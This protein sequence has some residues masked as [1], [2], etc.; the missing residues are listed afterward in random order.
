MVHRHQKH[1]FVVFQPSKMATNQWPGFKI[2]VS[3]D[4]LPDQTNGLL[5]SLCVDEDHLPA[6]EK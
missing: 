4:F 2:K 5:L 6:R 1:L 3:T